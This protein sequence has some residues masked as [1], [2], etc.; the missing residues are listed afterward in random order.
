MSPVEFGLECRKSWPAPYTCAFDS[1]I[2]SSAS[3]VVVP[4]GHIPAVYLDTYRW[5]N[6]HIYQ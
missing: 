2:K 1:V 3:K 6:M 4:H 5:A